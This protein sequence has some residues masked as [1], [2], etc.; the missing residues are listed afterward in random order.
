MS[1]ETEFFGTKIAVSKLNNGEV[2][3]FTFKNTAD[4]LDTKVTTLKVDVKDKT[5]EIASWGKKN[6]Y[7]QAI[8]KQVQLNGSA[9]SGLRFLRKAHYGNGLVLVRDEADANGK[10]QTKMVSLSDVPEIL[11]FSDLL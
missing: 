8:L 11:R 7:P 5:A 2:A 6:D 10:K 1:N 4:S 9:S 3:A